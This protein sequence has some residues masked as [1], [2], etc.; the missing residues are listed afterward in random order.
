MESNQYKNQISRRDFIKAA[1]L[2]AVALGAL[3]GVGAL[4]SCSSGASIKWDFETDVVVVGSGA[5]ACAAAVTAFSQ[6]SAVIMLEKSSAFGGTTAKSGGE[7][8]IPNNFA[9]HAQGIH[10]SKAECMKFMARAAYPT[11]FNPSDSLLGLPQHEY[12]LLSAYYDNGSKAIDYFMQIGACQFT[13][14][15][16]VLTD[17]VDHTTLNK[18][19]RGRG[20]FPKAANGSIGFGNELTTQMKT[21]IDAH[22][23]QVMMSSRVTQVVLSDKHEVLGIRATSN[24]KTIAVR[25]KKAVIFGSGGFTHNPELVLQYQ[26]G[27]TYGGCAVITNEGDFV[28]IAQAAGAQLSSMN[29]AWNAEIPLEPALQSPSTPNDIWQPAGDSMILVNKYGVRVTD[30]KRDYNDRTKLHFCW[31]PIQQ[32]YPNQIL[33][34]IYDQRTRDLFASA[35]GGYPIP[36][37]GNPSYELSGQT[38]QELGQSIRARV[39]QL[40]SS[41]GIFTLDAAFETNLAATVARFNQFANAGVD[42]DFQRGLYPYDAE[43]HTSTFS[44]PA[45]GTKWPANTLPNITMYPFTAQGPYYCILIAAGTLDTCAGPRTNELAQVLDTNEKPIPGFYGAGNCI[46]TPGHCYFAG[47]ATIGPALTYG[48]IAGVN[49]AK[50][51]VKSGNILP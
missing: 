8:W 7:A 5:A 34:M 50:E 47:G 13:Q 39:N 26:L 21:Y 32:E 18:V 45:Q 16:P 29:W 23:V 11:R 6:G 43:W 2:G 41:L 3:G 42:Q 4:A 19:P 37:S 9:L 27:P 35:P 12:N 28:Y 49:A 17:Y 46:A 44:I 25:G 15:N 1:G 51:P 36:T 38:F 48:Y 24:G 30:E 14:Q 33:F 20:I 22:K 10:D 31:D 40:S